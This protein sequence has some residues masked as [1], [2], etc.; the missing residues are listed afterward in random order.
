MDKVN[1]RKILEM[2]METEGSDDCSQYFFVTPKLLQNL[3]YKWEVN[4]MLM[5]NSPNTLTHR[6]FAVKRILKRKDDRRR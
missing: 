5:Y 3:N 6:R 4:V 1:E 2:L